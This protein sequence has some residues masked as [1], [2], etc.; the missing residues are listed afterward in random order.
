MRQ[1]SQRLRGAS[2]LPAGPAPVAPYAAVRA[3]TLE[4]ARSSVHAK[5]GQGATGTRQANRGGS[6]G[7]GRG[8]AGSLS[9]G[10]AGNSAPA[11]VGSVRNPAGDAVKPGIGRAEG[12]PG[13]SPDSC[14]CC[15]SSLTRSSSGGSLQGLRRA[16]AGVHRVG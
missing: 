5:R 9:C 1:R 12:V 15:S 2:S 11:E 3:M 6:A 8:V 16:V 7:P 4:S 10:G 14:E 13:M